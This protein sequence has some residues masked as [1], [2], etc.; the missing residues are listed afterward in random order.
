MSFTYYDVEL[1][2]LDEAALS[3][4]E[5]TQIAQRERIWVEQ[6]HGRGETDLCWTVLRSRDYMYTD[7]LCDEIRQLASHLSRLQAIIRKAK[8]MIRV[9]VF[10]HIPWKTTTIDFADILADFGAT[11]DVSFYPGEWE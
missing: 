7:D 10:A 6:R 8:P 5:R 4:S 11:M 1:C 3:E 9:G 2:L